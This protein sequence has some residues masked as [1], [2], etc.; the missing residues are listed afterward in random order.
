MVMSVAFM[1]RLRI[2][3]PEASISVIAKRGIDELL[4]FFP[5]TVHRF[6]FDKV[7]FRGLPGLWKFGRQI[8]KTEKFDVFFSLPDSFSSAV[9]GFASGAKSRVGYKSQGRSFL[10]THSYAK[11]GNLH[12]VHE[13]LQLLE[14]FTKQAAPVARVELLHQFTRKQHVVVNIN[15][16]AS[17]RRLT[18]TKAVEMIDTLRQNVQEEI[19]LIGAPKEKLFVNQVYQKLQ[20][21]DGIENLAGKTPLVQLVELLGSARMML[22]TDSG[23]AHLANALGTQTIVLF[24]AGNESNTAP[25]NA[26]LNSVVRLGKLSCEPC[27]KNTCVR[28][29]V[30]QCLQQ[31]SSEMIV[32]RVVHQ[33]QQAP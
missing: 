3:Y 14:F 25:F 20:C 23:P 6:V 21:T 22:S 4:N 12:R 19:V 24:G 29:D 27:L 13:Y 7:E 16:E 11:A 9:I 30:P 8:K 2:L 17:S 10:L 18:V 5:P 31:L 33:L 15:S 26:N 28:Y 1:H 32:N